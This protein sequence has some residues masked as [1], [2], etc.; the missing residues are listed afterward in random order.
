MEWLPFMNVGQFE[1]LFLAF[2]KITWSR[3]DLQLPFIQKNKEKIFVELPRF[4]SEGSIGFYRLLVEK[5][6]GN[7]LTSVV[8][9]VPVSISQSKNKLLSQGFYRF[10]ID[11]SY[12]AVSKNR[13]KTIKSRVV[14]SEQIQPSTTFNFNK[15]LP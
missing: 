5:M 12:E 14:K 9:A 11:L 15:G 13:I 4:I 3:F 7:G 10:L 1:G 6:V 8:P 2:S